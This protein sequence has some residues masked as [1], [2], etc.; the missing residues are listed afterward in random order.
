MDS[1]LNNYAVGEEKPLSSASMVIRCARA[2]LDLTKPKIAV[3]SVITAMAVY[4]SAAE[5]LAPSKILAFLLAC[6]MAAGGSLAFNQWWERDSDLLMHRTRL[7]P[8][9]Q[10]IISPTGALIWSITLSL[11]GCLLLWS[12]F[13]ALTAGLGLATILVYAGIYTPMKRRSTWATE[14]GSISGALP[15]LLGAAAAGDIASSAAWLFAAA[16]F[17]WQM[18]HFYAIGW[19]HRDDYRAAG[20]PLLP[21]CDSDGRRTGHWMQIYSTMLVLLI[22]IPWSAGLIPGISGA[23]ALTGSLWIFIRSWK[24]HT[25]KGDRIPA[26]RRLFRATLLTLPAI[27]ILAL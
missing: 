10:N 27:L 12:L 5:T 23:I 19:I 21:V 26:A 20:L 14:V 16:L 13:G 11:A 8:L 7:R 3:A 25:A 24:F 2:L 17:L 18:P 22:L 4:V 15:P 9:P 6:G 1:A